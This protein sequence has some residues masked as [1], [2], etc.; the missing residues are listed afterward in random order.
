M[1]KAIFLDRDG[2]INV[3]KE[4]LHKIKDFEFETGAL[5]ALKIFKELEYEIVVVT[6]Q[7]GIARGYYTEEELIKLNKHMEEEVRKNDG[8][9]LKCYYCPHHPEKG[10]DKYKMQCDCRKPEPGMLEQGIKEFNIER[11]SSYMVGDKISDIDAG[12]KSGLKAVLVKTGYGKKTFKELSE[13]KKAEI[14]IFENLLE[15]ALHL[16]SNCF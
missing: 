13:N 4:Y 8:E 6:N 1:K 3:E 7:S 11:E 9:I 16:K 12:K 14:M 2:T 10:L 15:F 5:E